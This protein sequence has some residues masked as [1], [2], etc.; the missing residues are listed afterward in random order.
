MIKK[1]IY[2]FKHYQHVEVLCKKAFK[3]WEV[4]AFGRCPSMERL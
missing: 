1:T 3:G 2:V 4:K